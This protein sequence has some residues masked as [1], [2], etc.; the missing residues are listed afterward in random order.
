MFQ[1]LFERSA[2]AIW[3]FD[4]QAGVFTDCNQAAAELLG[5]PTKQELLRRRPAELSPPLQPDGCASEVAAVEHTR[6]VDRE[7]RHRFEWTARRADGGEVQLEVTATQISD[8]GRILHVVMSRD[9]SERKRAE[10]ELRES[11][12]MLV[13]VAD[14]IAEAIYRSDPAHRLTFVN[15]AYLQLF[16]FDSLRELQAIP[17]E[18]LYAD[19]AVRARLLELLARDDGFRQQEVEYVR[20]DGRRFWGLASARVVR[21]PQTAKALYHVGTIAD[22]T[23]R[24]QMEAELRAS[25]QRWRLLFEQSPFSIQV[26]APDGRSLRVNRGWEELFGTTQAALGQYNV[27]QDQQL[28]AH[29]LLPLVERGLAGEVVRLPPI[30]YELPTQLEGG[31]RGSKWVRAILF[32][33]LDVQGR[34]VEVVCVHEDITNRKRAEDE[35]RQLNAELERRIAERT[36]ELSASEARLRTLVEHAPESMVVLDGAGCGFQN[37][38][39]N[40]A[41]LFG[42]T[43]EELLNLGPAEVSPEFQPDGRRSADL[44]RGWIEKAL[45]GGAPRFEWVHKHKDGRLIPCEVRLVRLPGEGRTLVRGSILDNTERHHRERVQQATYRIS[46]AVL[47]AEDLP[48]LFRRIHETVGT[49]MPAR[50]FYIALLDPATD[51]FHF[52]YFVDERDTT[53]APMKL[54]TGLTGYVIRTR[55]P[56]LVNRATHIEKQPVGRAVLADEG[57]EATYVESGTPSAVWLGVP[58]TIRGRT[59]GVMAVQ[60]YHHDSAYGE[61]EKQILTFIGEQTALAIGRKRAEQALRESEE[62]FRAL[63]EATRQG[64]MLHDEERVFA[65]N[66]AALRMLGYAQA[67]EVLGKPPTDLSAPLQQGNVPAQEL[68]RGHIRTALETGS[69]RFEWLGRRVDGTELPLE[70]FLT[71]VEIGGR[72]V[73]QT[74]I[75]DITERKQA[76]GELLRALAREKELGQLKSSFVSMVSHEFRT[77]LGI[78]LSSA[79]IL[80]DYFEQLD[81]TERRQHLQSIQKGTRRMAELME[82]VLVLSRFEAGKMQFQPARVDLRALCQR[83]ADEV[84]S[85]SG[86]VCPIRLTADPRLREAMADERL[87]RH[88][89]TNLLSNA[90]KYSAPGSVVEFGVESRTNEAL[91]VIRDHGIGIP[92]EDRAWLFNAFHRGRNVGERP[93]SGLGLV[94]VQRCVE[95]HGGSIQVASR[96]G[97]GTTVT[98]RLPVFG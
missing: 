75:N 76:E 92:E 40:A 45:T 85:A 79:E 73:I 22:I 82:E 81:A 60:D 11:Q 23:Q 43:R 7:G 71:T 38:N 54:S 29:G 78:I 30:P 49:L 28:A 33:L 72:K 95:L 67:A 69:A 68:A 93:G 59:L 8:G 91:W 41:R 83:V 5:Y 57:G 34:V 2:D 12:Q 16:G 3:L 4:P 77:P 88:I 50:N 48:S 58:L 35:V 90:V 64:V 42:F 80:E 86:R 26:F 24:R 89:L 66:P 65:I 44:A 62:K 20:Q 53:P 25:E 1:L 56:L 9:L 18:R 39:D 36:A 17:R 96:V 31:A 15:R 27:L 87:L 32:P 94:I 47:T 52:E 61:E 74:V 19:A 70:V 63:F 97:E 84:S 6:R 51:Q 14:N 98:V 21:H 55:K 10:A 46:E 13:S 37:C